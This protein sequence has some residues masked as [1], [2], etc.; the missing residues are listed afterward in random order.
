[1][2]ESAN[3]LNRPG[4]SG[5]F[6]V[7]LIALGL[8][9][10]VWQTACGGEPQPISPT[11]PTVTPSATSSNTPVS[12]VVPPSATP[13][14]SATQGTSSELRSNKERAAPSTAN[15]DLA[16]VVDGNSAFSFDLYQTLRGRDGNLFYSPH[17]ISLALAMTFAGAGGQTERQM[18]DTLGFSLPRTDFTPRSTTWTSTSPPAE[19]AMKGSG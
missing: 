16:A 3:G 6:C 10:A 15:A 8:T 7:L 2:G 4:K 19:R 5:W 12:T 1:M 17:S 14:R 11:S 13:V 9:A 18:A